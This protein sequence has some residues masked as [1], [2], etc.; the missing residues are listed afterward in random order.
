VKARPTPSINLKAIDTPGTN[1][2]TVFVTNEVGSGTYCAPVT[3]RITSDSAGLN[4]ITGN[5]AY[6]TGDWLVFD[7]DDCSKTLHFNVY[8][9]ATYSLKGVAKEYEFTC[10]GY[11]STN[12]ARAISGPIAVH[13]NKNS[14]L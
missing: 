5:I 13:H 12:P 2:G 1:P 14:G 7:N 10:V 3:R 8:L 11:C 4:V 9:E 6:I